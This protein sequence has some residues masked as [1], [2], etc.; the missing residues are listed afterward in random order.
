MVHI[1]TVET[2]EL[3]K[4]V[5]S[6][7]NYKY[8]CHFFHLLLLLILLLLLLLLLLLIILNFEDNSRDRTRKLHG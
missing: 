2:F 5:E 7:K 6:G 8:L 3:T 4:V 1:M